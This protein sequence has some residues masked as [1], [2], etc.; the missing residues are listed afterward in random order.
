M[1]VK[2]YACRYCELIS[3]NPHDFIGTA[4]ESGD[5]QSFDD[6]ITDEYHRADAL[7]ERLEEALEEGI[8]LQ[9][10]LNQLHE[11]YD[12]DMQRQIV[13]TFEDAYCDYFYC[14]EIEI[15]VS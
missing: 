11:E 12:R 3:A 14:N 2:V 6:W 7:V 5:L 9:E 10:V 13:L 1:K 4:I 15:A 8:T